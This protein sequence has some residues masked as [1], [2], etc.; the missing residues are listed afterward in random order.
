MEELLDVEDD[1]WVVRG[2]ASPDERLVNGAEDHEAEHS[3]EWAVSGAAIRG[4]SPVE[5][6]KCCPWIRNPVV[7]AAY[8][9]DL[10]EAGFEVYSDGRPHVNIVFPH[11]PVE[12]DAMLE[13]LRK[14]LAHSFTNPNYV[15]KGKKGE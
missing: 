14:A 2:G 4:L 10:R 11:V 3:G 5:I 8:A 1:E 6:A 12:G 7:H 9:A 13:H 15:P